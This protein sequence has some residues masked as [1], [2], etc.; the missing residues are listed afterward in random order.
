MS[1]E[2]KASPPHPG[3]RRSLRA[4]AKV[5][6]QLPG[7]LAFHTL[8][9]TNRKRKPGQDR[10]WDPPLEVGNG[11]CWQLP[12]LQG[13]FSKVL[14]GGDGVVVARALRSVSAVCDLIHGGGC[15]S[16]LALPGRVVHAVP[17]LS[18]GSGGGLGVLWVAGPGR[19]NLLFCF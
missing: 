13:P 11:G 7:T 8:L 5:Q 15:L 14:L 10:S 1:P 4:Q 2:P 6:G 16:S 19:S 9:N 3:P 18:L 17:S 12:K